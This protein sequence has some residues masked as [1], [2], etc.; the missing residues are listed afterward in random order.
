MEN[1]LHNYFTLLGAAVEIPLLYDIF[2][3]LGASVIV[4]LIC[5][6]LNIPSILGF[7]IT[8]IIIG[9]SA[10][11][12]QSGTTEI[13]MMAEIGIILLL[14]II[15]LE[16]SLAS[17]SAIKRTVLLG[18]LVQVG[19]TIIITALL[20]IIFN[21]EI[22]NAVFFGFLFSL[23]S[24]A[25]VLKMVQE[26]GIM[27]SPHGKIS[28]AIL[29]FQD[30]IVVP[31]ILFTP[32]IAG[33]S[34]NVTKELIL[35][36]AKV[37]IIVII[38]ILS[39]RYLVP[40]LL[41]EVAKTK[42]QELFILTIV[43]ICVST[44]WLTNQ[45]GLSLA[46]GAFMAG[47]IISESDYSHQA[48]GNILPFREVFT[49]FFFVSIGMLLNLE[50]LFEHILIILGLTIAVAVMKFAIAGLA[51]LILG[52]PTR[53]VILTGLLLFQVGE[54]AFILSQSGV[55][56]GLLSGEYYQYFIA[57]SIL[58]MALTPF[59]ITKSDAICN[60][61]IRT[62]IPQKI[63]QLR[64]TPASKENIDDIVE[65]L[66]DHIVIIGY[67]LN[68][69]NVARAAKH[70]DIPYIILE[71]NA[72]TVKNELEKGERIIYGDG[73]SPHILEQVH[74]ENARV[75]VVAISDTAAINRVIAGI[76][77]L[78]KSVHIIVRTRFINDIEE[79]M[80]IG[81]DEVIP[82]EFETSI[83]IF[84]LVLHKYLVPIDSIEEIT[85]KIRQDN[86][87]IFSQLN[88]SRDIAN[89]FKLP[90]LNI[91]ILTVQKTGS[92]L[93]GKSLSEIDVRN[94]FGVN[95]IAIRRN[96]EFLER[97]DQNTQILKDDI[98]YVLGKTEDIR[99]FYDKI[100]T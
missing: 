97:I 83:E 64:N 78:T 33:Q 43:V 96:E 88:K 1:F 6:K 84:S 19:G 2:V 94:R 22:A 46:L 47:L 30:I 65:H 42:S 23:S 63:S 5:K 70:L 24:T 25:I 99:K 20:L 15:G 89:D 32:I 61:I 45:A 90:N 75:V 36:A 48:T 80:K 79:H 69:R 60:F 51:A 26:R 4:V 53:T 16:F 3:I 72:N 57:V 68:G 13:E 98:L 7:L 9:P 39:A 81:A 31:M 91:V 93:L 44:A 18:G 85:E 58:T 40:R 73:I 49:S 62:Q 100:S 71:M 10:L 86:Y 74:I 12:I 87:N 11:N 67:G 50:F 27:N 56:A 34:D 35:L 8:G 38:L 95:I 14:F 54:F 59:L 76:R 28:I 77:A 17:L 29:I 21:F 52:F 92:S 82:E 41:Y 66:E 55:S 37:I